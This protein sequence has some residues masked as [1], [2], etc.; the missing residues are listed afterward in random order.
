MTYFK[1]WQFSINEGCF[2]NIHVNFRTGFVYVALSDRLR[3]H[4]GPR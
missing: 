2:P 3:W 4:N 1:R